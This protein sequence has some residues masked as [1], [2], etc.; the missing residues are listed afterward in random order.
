[1]RPASAGALADTAPPPPPNQPALPGQVSQAGRPP[2]RSESP[3][4]PPDPT[5]PTRTRSGNPSHWRAGVASAAAP[6]LREVRT[7]D[8]KPPASVAMR[9]RRSSRVAEDRDSSTRTCRWPSVGPWPGRKARVDINSRSGIRV[10]WQSVFETRIVAATVFGDTESGICI[11]CI[12]CN[13]PVGWEP[14]L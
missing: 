2:R 5:R 12:H 4:P 7:E 1:M 10:S 3:P 14:H 13:L 11:R 6:Q 8:G 9:T